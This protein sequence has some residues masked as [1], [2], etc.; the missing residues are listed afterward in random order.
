MY[1][2]GLAILSD[3]DMFWQPVE[4]HYNESHRHYHNWAHIEEMIGFIH[5]CR[6]QV[7]INSA[8]QETFSE[9]TNLGL[10]HELAILFHDAVYV[11]GSEVSENA[12]MDLMRAYLSKYPQEFPIERI[13][14]IAYYI[15]TTKNHRSNNIDAQVIIDLDLMRL[16]APFEQFLV[17]ADLIRKEYDGVSDEDFEKGRIAF[18]EDMLSR[19]NIFYT[20]YGREHWQPNAIRNLKLSLKALKGEE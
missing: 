14:R 18:M 20:K 2:F 3:Y 12:S 19:D 5:E 13:E 10:D 17:N 6:H 15:Q 16:A 11:P 7:S 1:R 8:L 4:Y 9:F